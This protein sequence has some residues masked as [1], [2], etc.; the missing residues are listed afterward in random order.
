M[1]KKSEFPKK[2]LVNV[3]LKGAPKKKKLQEGPLLMMGS[4]EM[5]SKI[6]LHKTLCLFGPKNPKTYLS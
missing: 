6:H 4:S 1:L 2:I 3:A 5:P